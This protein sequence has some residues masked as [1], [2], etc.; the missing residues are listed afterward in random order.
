[1]GFFKVSAKGANNIYWGR[2]VQF[3]SVSDKH[4]RCHN[5]TMEWVIFFERQD[6]FSSQALKMASALRPIK[7][8]LG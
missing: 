5:S 8:P 1:M 2:L 3:V 6:G 7:E 4:T